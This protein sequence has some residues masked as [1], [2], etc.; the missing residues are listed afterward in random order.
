MPVDYWPLLPLFT[1]IAILYIRIARSASFQIAKASDSPLK[2]SRILLP[3]AIGTAACFFLFISFGLFFEMELLLPA[4][5]L[6]AVSSSVLLAIW[7]SAK[8]PPIQNKDAGSKPCPT[9]GYDLRATPHR[10]PECGGI[11][12]TYASS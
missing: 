8:P 6:C 4:I 5:I 11:P 7:N 3:V 9:C 2:W 12:T 10:C 1:G